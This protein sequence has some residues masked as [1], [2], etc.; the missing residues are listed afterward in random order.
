[1]NEENKSAATQ[2][3]SNEPIDS[4]RERCGAGMIEAVRKGRVCEQHKYD[5]SMKS[6]GGSACG[7]APNAEHT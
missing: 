7:A 6:V 5:E 2:Y 3:K 1:M 4:I